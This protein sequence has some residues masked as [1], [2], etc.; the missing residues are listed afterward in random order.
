M[1][2]RQAVYPAS[3]REFMTLLGGAVAAWPIAAS[4][5]RA[6]VPEIG[7][8][9]SLS[10]GPIAD[11]LDAFL[12]GLEDTR[13]V[14]GRNVTIAYRSAEGQAALL[15]ALAADL[16]R[17]NPKVIVCLTS[18]NTVR[19]AM[20]ATSTI[21]IVFAIAG[22]PAEL[23]LVA[24][25]DRPEANVTGAGRRTEELNPERL[26]VICELVPQPSPVGFLLNS[27]SVPPATTSERIR[28]ME[29]AAQSVGRRLVVLDLAGNPE[30]GTI[31]ADMAQQGIAAFVISTEALF[32]V[33]RD[34]VI[35][36]SAS[37]GIA[38]M[39]PNREYAQAGGLIS[40]GADLYEHYRVAGTYAGRI[41]KGEKPSD[42][43]V[44]L[45]TKFEMVINLRTAKA[46][47]LTVPQALLRD[48]TELIE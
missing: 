28:A 39:F 36:L 3:R 16:V 32:N 24:N 1:E 31:F 27:D 42:M 45:P 21:P 37:Y 13:F 30:L 41:L 10:F 7:I 6:V 38:A 48:A 44:Q 14:E 8:L 43:P 23:G 34:Q 9:N 33:W 15:P 5:Q 18:A 4:A 12:E 20:G 29:A 22:D 25:P 46:L 47:G 17:R 11:R 2:N 35:G 40:Y 19:A 26:K